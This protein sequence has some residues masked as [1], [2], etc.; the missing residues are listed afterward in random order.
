MKRIEKQQ[1][2]DDRILAEYADH[3]LALRR[4]LEDELQ[5]SL[6]ARAMDFHEELDQLPRCYRRTAARQPVEL[7]DQGAEL[8]YFSLELLFASHA[9]PSL[10]YIEQDRS[11]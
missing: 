4:R 7:A 1:V 3:C 2:A 10:S 5:D 6:Q 8:P 9:T 11:S